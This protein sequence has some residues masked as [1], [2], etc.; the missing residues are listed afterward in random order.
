MKIYPDID[1]HWFKN[2]RE[3]DTR[4]NKKRKNLNCV[5]VYLICSTIYWKSMSEK[6]YLLEI[7]RFIVKMKYKPMNVFNEIFSFVKLIQTTNHHHLSVVRDTRL[8]IQGFSVGVFNFS[9][10]IYEFYVYRG[11]WCVF[12][13]RLSTTTTEYTLLMW[14]GVN[15]NISLFILISYKQHTDRL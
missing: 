4:N 7:P 2:V 3:C 6:V 11:V 12:Y 8:C 14:N 13:V 10:V 5:K 15:Y 1:T 9:S